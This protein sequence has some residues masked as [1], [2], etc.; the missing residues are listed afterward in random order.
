MVKPNQILEK[1]VLFALLRKFALSKREKKMKEE[2]NFYR[3]IGMRNCW[4]IISTE[5][6]VQKEELSLYLGKRKPVGK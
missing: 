4:E 1:D 6:W 3:V 5:E 2:R